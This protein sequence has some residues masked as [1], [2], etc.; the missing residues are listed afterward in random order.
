ML[1]SSDI[2]KYVGSLSCSNLWVNLFSYDELSIN[3]RQKIVKAYAALLSRVLRRAMTAEDI[4]LLERRKII[5]DCSL[6][7]YDRLSEICSYINELP[8]NTVCLLA[9]CKQCDLINSVML[10]KIIS[11]VTI[12][13]AC[14]HIDCPKFLTKKAYDTLNKMKEAVLLDLQKLLKLK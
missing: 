3:I 12:L 9:T 8:S 14:D 4:K 6:S 11:D 13:D 2:E 10:D 7:Y 1:S 5:V